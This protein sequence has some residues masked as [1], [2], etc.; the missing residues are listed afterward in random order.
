MEE[1]QIRSERRLSQLDVGSVCV[2]LEPK[3]IGWDGRQGRRQKGVGKHGE[4]SNYARKSTSILDLIKMMMTCT[5]L[6]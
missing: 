5:N 6:K 1:C 3:Y 2:K 4:K